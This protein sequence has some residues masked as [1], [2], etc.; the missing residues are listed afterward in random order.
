M[1][2]KALILVAVAMAQSAAAQVPTWHVTED[3]RIGSDSGP[4]SFS[5]IRAFGATKPG[6]IFILDFK[7]QEL[8]MF[9]AKGNFVRLAARKGGGPG[10][11]SNGN[12]LFVAADDRIW[13]N[14]PNSARFSVYSGDGKFERQI[15][16]PTWGY[17]YT[18]TGIVDPKGRI[19]EYYSITTPAGER[20]A[21]Y[22]RITSASKI[23][24]LA[25]PSCYSHLKPEPPFTGRGAGGSTVMGV[26][27][28]PRTSA[29]LD[30]RGTQWCTAG[31]EY[32]VYNSSLETQDSIAVVRGKA[33]HLPVTPAERAAAI[34]RVDSV[35]SKYAT[36]D[37]DYSRIPTVKPVINAIFADASGRLWVEKTAASPK[38]PSEF[39]VWDTTGRQVAT[40]RLGFHAETG[41]RPVVI[42]NYLYAIALDDDDVQYVVRAKITP[43]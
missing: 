11:L 9:D 40:A 13:V 14:D 28:Q 23:D 26:P 6:A 42:G 2:K 18:W 5:S 24:T 35:L 20:V 22:R 19:V 8:R 12:G 15:I 29:I 41:I 30:A 17:G 38:A 36:K 37:A 7:S 3:L 10:E 43:R 33:A 16:V 31:D 27:F 1:K 25:M 21:K 32:L 4:A 39:D 34:A